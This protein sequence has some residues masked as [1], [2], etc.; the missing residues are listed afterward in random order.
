MTN[1]TDSENLEA[2]VS[3]VG[4]PPVVVAMVVHQ[5]CPWL[6][7]VVA[8]IAGQDYPNLQTL[9]FLTGTTTATGAETDVIRQSLP[10]AVIRQVE[11][12][13]GYG[14]LM[15]EVSRLV[16]GESG[17]FCFMH[18][19]VA[20]DS[21]AI[22]SMI[23]EM[24][25]SNA[26]VVGPKI[27]MWDD[28][29]ILQSVGLGADRIGDIS[30]NVEQGEKDQEQH[31]AVRDVFL[32]PSACM[33]VR[34]DL[35][36]ELGGYSPDIPLFGEDLDFCWRT[37]LSGARVL[38]VPAARARHRKEMDATRSVAT[39]SALE[40][41]HR[42]RT[43]AT[44]SG[45]FQLP[46]VL[47][48]LLLMAVARV[49]IGVFN[50][51]LRQ[52]LASLRA[53][54]AV[55]FDARYIIRRRAEVRPF[56]RVPVA[57]IHDLQS[58]G[59]ARLWAFIRKRR[60]RVQEISGLATANIKNPKSRLVSVTALVVFALIVIGSRGLI[61]GG[62]ASVG[63][64]LP[65]RSGS[66]SPRLLISST[67]SG[68]WQ[69]GFGQASAN[70]TGIVLLAIAGVGVLGRLGALQAL[71]IIGALFAGCIGMW[72]VASG[73]FGSRA[74]MVGLLV[75]AAVPVPYAAIAHGRFG[76][77]MCYAALPWMLRLFARAGQR[78]D[79]VQK[80]QL[81]AVTVLFGAMV[82]AFVPTFLILVLF[83]SVAWMAADLVS[84]VR[85]Q[86]VVAVLQM[87]FVL[88]VGTIVLNFPWSG[89][90][91]VADWWQRII[92][93]QTVRVGDVGLTTLA[94]MDSGVVAISVL[95]LGLYVPVIVGL[96]IVRGD[97]LVWAAR[98]AT[99]VLFAILAI[100]LDDAG[101]IHFA[102]P[103]YGILFVVVAC[104][105]SLAA[106][107]MASFVF[108]DQAVS[109]YRWWKPLASI[110]L[111]SILIGCLPSIAFSANGRWGQP[112]VSLA[113]LL[114]QLPTDPVSGDYNVVYVGRS[115]VLPLPAIRLN[116][117]TAF[118]IAD[119]GELTMRDHWLAPTNALTD[120]V[121]QALDAAISQQT[122]RSGRLLSSLAVRYLV[123]PIIDGAI[124]TTDKPLDAPPGL[125][126]GLSL[127]LDFR[128]VY[129]ANDLVIFENMAYTPSLSR[130]DEASAVLSQQAG[131]DA[132][133]SSQLRV[134][135]VAP[136]TRDI[137]SSPTPIDVGTVHL[138]VPF[139]DRLVLRVDGSDVIPRVA[140]GGT[141]AFD[142]PVAGSATLG[143]RT[144]WTHIVLLLVQL[145]LWVTVISVTFDLRSLKARI[146]VRRVGPVVL[147]GSS[148]ASLVFK[149][150][151]SVESQ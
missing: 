15:N 129:T 72:Q 136:R 76:V 109:S 119:D 70:P 147:G 91:I 10:A 132:L 104:G 108:D 68:W 146:G 81:W 2:R 98:S 87:M 69:A 3:H 35:F 115:D 90:F 16:E 144:P 30:P 58:R 86:A 139:S 13:P 46:V 150:V 45:R 125:L 25:R 44:L 92:G 134:A 112:K 137:D 100:A 21:N 79:G 113:Q 133:L 37:H 135:Q 82:S 4:A 111:V 20:L 28:I 85:L 84:R 7:D 123:V 50:G 74:R 51:T 127:Q 19:D 149:E 52:A 55:M 34:A 110:A 12:N 40:A 75:Y 103:E 114:T 73:L 56:R 42:V 102:L 33:L 24:F 140:F 32:I 47:V 107:T 61:G 57:E 130:L 121:A 29:S 54:I 6:E 43:V 62:V 18:D 36:R 66:E 22:S 99:L 138:A 142:S 27:V 11:G 101:Y 128:R 49:V 5:P 1:S 151:E 67:L 93:V 17:I 59:S 97:K 143:F 78:P 126:E 122:V 89:G 116:D 83:A 105:L 64:F 31:D 9:F 80:T 48:Q 65:I 94:R 41:R 131:T 96:L 118:A 8:S 26:G 106:A 77:L 120:S 141:T 63:E 88:V 14:P 71:A 124:S 145:L 53:S 117:Q 38:V 39:M 148:D 23:E 95:A 60:S